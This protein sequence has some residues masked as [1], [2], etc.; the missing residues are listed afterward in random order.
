MQLFTSLDVGNMCGDD[1]YEADNDVC[2][3]VDTHADGNDADDAHNDDDD[4]DD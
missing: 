1:D 4:G 3:L 2:D